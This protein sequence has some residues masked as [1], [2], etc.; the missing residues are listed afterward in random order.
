MYITNYS[1][2]FNNVNPI[3]IYIYYICS[4]MFNILFE[5]N[6]QKLYIFE[7]YFWDHIIKTKKI[8][9][10]TILDKALKFDYLNLKTERKHSQ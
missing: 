7:V 4:S 6:E 5:L 2:L 10:S 3:Y 9:L 1:L 8:Y